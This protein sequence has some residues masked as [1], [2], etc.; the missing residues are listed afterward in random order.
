RTFASVCR[1]ESAWWQLMHLGWVRTL[2]MGPNRPGSDTGA[3]SL[4]LHAVTQDTAWSTTTNK[5]RGRITFVLE[6][7]EAGVRA[8]TSGPASR[9]LR[10]WRSPAQERSRPSGAHPFLRGPR[11]WE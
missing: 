6:S 4:R 5:G 11:S 8:A 2:A 7:A 9:W 3:A 10:R 1:G